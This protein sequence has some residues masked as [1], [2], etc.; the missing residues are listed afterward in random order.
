MFFVQRYALV[1]L[2]NQN[3]VELWDW[4]TRKSDGDLQIAR[5]QIFFHFNP[6]LCI[7]RIKQLQAK[8]GPRFNEVDDL[9]VAPNSNGDK[10]ACKDHYLY[11]LFLT[12]LKKNCF[13]FS[14]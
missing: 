3:L 2:D 10:I 12:F 6:K 1:V 9:S 4:N 13:I 14:R 11:R 8:L 5:G 7:Y